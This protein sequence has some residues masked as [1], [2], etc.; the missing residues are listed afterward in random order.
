[1][2]IHLYCLLPRS[3]D[4]LAPALEGIG[5]APV[6]AVAVGSV[7]AWVS[8]LPEP[9][10]PADAAAL[11]AHDAV[12]TAA[13]SLATPLPARFGQRFE[14]DDECRS[15]LERREPAL[16]AG[17]AEVAGCVEMRVLLAPSREAS[18]T[19]RQR[20]APDGAGE[21]GRAYLERV[22][23]RVEE[24]RFLHERALAL[25][26]TLLPVAGRFAVRDAVA[27]RPGNAAPV[28]LAHLVRRGDAGAWRDA[29]EGALA[30]IRRSGERTALAGPVAPYSF[31][32]I[33]DVASG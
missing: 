11:L 32:E 12:A 25:R 8:T 29:V 18:R 26:A 2:P 9:T 17:L 31:S 4:V 15:A 20:R 5:G 10:P 22:K 16:R 14:S 28:V 30:A 6:R 27:V 1:M 3:A 13:L 21:S 24:D 33:D 23:T 19:T 7:A